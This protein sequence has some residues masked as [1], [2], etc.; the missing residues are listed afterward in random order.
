M[1]SGSRCFLRARAVFAMLLG[2]ASI[3]LASVAFASEAGA[4]VPR[5]KRVAR[6]SRASLEYRLSWGI[7]AV[8]AARVYSKGVSGDEVTVAL[9]DTGIAGVPANLFTKVSPHSVDLLQTRSED[10]AGSEHG[11]QTAELVAAA[12]D[13]YGTVG[14][15]YGATLMSIRADIEGSCKIECAVRATDLARGIDYALEHGA[16]IIGVPL[17]GP[18]PLRV[19][20]P[21][22]ER[23]A[24]AGAVIVAAAGNEAR[25]A[26]S[27]PARYAAD[28]RF[29]QA[30]VVAGASDYRGNLVNWT[31]R[32]KGSEERYLAAPGQ[33]VVVGCDE[34]Y[35][36]LVSGTSFSV[37]YVVGALALLLDRHPQMNAQHAARLLLDGAQDV[38]RRGTDP[39]SGRGVLDVARAIRV[40]DK[41]AA[42][43]PG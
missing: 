34:K 25:E 30:M 40:A 33:N 12:L 18:D 26:P 9:I 19:I 8:N 29:A 16:R 15:A 4:G 17:V 37:S 7:E 22:L 6:P 31:S 20:E 10:A 41:W 24:A 43:E 35:C 39:I 28:P 23:A 1:H 11:R 3:S 42:R 21:A 38:G 32:A 27:Y 13:G 2:L 14:V 36:R 5:E